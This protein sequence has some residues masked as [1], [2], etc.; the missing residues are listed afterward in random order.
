MVDM[1][2]TTSASEAVAGRRLA[3]LTGTAEL[4]TC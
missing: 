4:L 1:T 3:A 2:D